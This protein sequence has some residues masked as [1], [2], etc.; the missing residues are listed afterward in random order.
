MQSPSVYSATSSPQTKVSPDFLHSLDDMT[1]K[2][3]EKLQADLI[4]QFDYAKAEAVKQKLEDK[5]QEVKTEDIS[6][7][8]DLFKSKVEVIINNYN[9]KH[10]ELIDRYNQL[11]RKIRF[12]ASQ[13]FHQ[14][15]IRHIQ[16]LVEYEKEYILRHSKQSVKIPQSVYSLLDRAEIAAHNKKFEQA[17]ELFDLASSQSLSYHDLVKSINMKDYLFVRK[18]VLRSQKIEISTLTEQLRS[19][20][21]RLKSD[22]RGEIE[23]LKTMF[24]KEVTNTQLD[25]MKAINKSLS[26]EGRKIAQAQIREYYKDALNRFDPKK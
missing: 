19:N 26:A 18:E 14:L 1:V 4:D 24:N 17:Q 21:T 8:V 11:E 7:S 2:E 5:K 12:D 10:N 13:A 6:K 20:M 25:S 16:T 22:I 15:Q 3:L 23:K 9:I